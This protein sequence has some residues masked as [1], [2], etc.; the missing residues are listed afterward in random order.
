MVA[1]LQTLG[2]VFVGVITSAATWLMFGKTFYGP[3]YD[4]AEEDYNMASVVQQQPPNRYLQPRGQV[5][6]TMYPK[7]TELRYFR[8]LPKEGDALVLVSASWLP[9]QPRELQKMRNLI[10]LFWQKGHGDV[11]VGYLSYENHARRTPTRII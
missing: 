6:E 1:N 10:D 8:T 5:P 3:T 7:Q 9:S 4:F 11:K 2:T